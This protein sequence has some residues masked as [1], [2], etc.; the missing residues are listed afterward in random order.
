[1]GVRI[2][3]VWALGVV[4]GLAFNT[5]AIAAEKMVKF[6][7]K[8]G[9][10]AKSLTGKPGNAVNG[11][12][13]AIKRKLGNCL[14]CHVLPIPEQAYHG[15]I[16][17]ELNG[18]ASRLSEGEIRMRIVNPKMANPDTIMPAFYKNEGFERV[19][20]KFKGKSMLTASQVEDLVAYT[21]TL[22]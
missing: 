9:A 4:L 13:L 3:A 8:D 10:I 6:V 18:V 15:L 20:K 21:M 11:R 5:N 7:M 22:K 2:V 19:L 12:K 1:M 17:P 16:G 14:A